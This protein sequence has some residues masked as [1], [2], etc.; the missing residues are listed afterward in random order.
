VPTTIQLLHRWCYCGLINISIPRPSSSVNG[1]KAECTALTTTAR[2]YKD[3]PRN[4]VLFELR[5]SHVVSEFT[6][7]YRVTFYPNGCNRHWTIRTGSRHLR[8]PDLV[9]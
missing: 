9:P 4:L 2:T 1:V 3:E 8:T 5:R 7:I 6:P